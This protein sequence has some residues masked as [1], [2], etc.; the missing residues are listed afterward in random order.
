MNKDLSKPRPTPQPAMATTP[1]PILLS[2]WKYMSSFA[3]TDPGA[4]PPQL[5]NQI[6]LG[7]ATQGFLA[8]TIPLPMEG[9]WRLQFYFGA[10]A[11]DS[12]ADP[13]SVFPTESQGTPGTDMINA[14]ISGERQS[15]A[16]TKAVQGKR[17]MVVQT[18]QGTKVCSPCCAT[19][20]HA[21]ARLPARAPP[22][23]RE[24]YRQRAR[25]RGVGRLHDCH[26]PFDWH[27]PL[28]RDFFSLWRRSATPSAF[29]R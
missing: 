3:N 26:R 19:H 23:E 18:V 4:G 24:T 28:Q 12:K 6:Q 7:A 27:L 17:V 10:P 21:H 9:T 16:S 8:G 1:T 14:T 13:A 11:Y 5:A 29:S 22:P 15:F 20:M 2:W 25:V